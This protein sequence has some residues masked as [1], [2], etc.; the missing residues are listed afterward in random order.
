M[1]LPKD[2]SEMMP[3]FKKIKRGKKSIGVQREMVRCAKEDIKCCKILYEKEFYSKSTY[4][5]QQ[6]TEK[7]AKAYGM[8]YG[9]IRPED[10]TNISHITP[11]IYL[12]VLEESW[13]CNI[14]GALKQISDGKLQTNTNPIKEL[15][16]RNPIK[17]AKIE[18]KEIEKMIKI[19]DKVR[20]KILNPDLK[21]LVYNVFNL[22]A[23]DKKFDGVLELSIEFTNLYVLACITFPHEAFTRYPDGEIKP[24]EYS[25][26]MG[27][28]N[29]TK[30]LT[31]KVE[32]AIKMLE[33]QI[34][35]D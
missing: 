25:K 21:G 11:R 20:E 15:V 8:F 10:R 26:E 16:E 2:S 23:P 31:E 18:G 1:N 28:V 13:V 33:N 7:I 3:D 4:F 32:S 22:L 9:I 27:I 6:A 29:Q 19:L 35:I 5:L 12:K 34:S 17:L 30:L 24:W 14:A